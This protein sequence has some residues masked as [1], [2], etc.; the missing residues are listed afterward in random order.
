MI[1]AT[2]LPSHGLL[3]FSVGIAFSITSTKCFTA[4]FHHQSKSRQQLVK[5][6]FLSDVPRKRFGQTSLQRYNVLLFV[7]CI[8]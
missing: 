2:D 3:N 4:V 7:K 6:N 1:I 5:D 8:T